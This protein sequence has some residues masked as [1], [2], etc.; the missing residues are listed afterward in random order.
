MIWPIASMNAAVA[1][2]SLGSLRSGETWSGLKMPASLA[3]AW[4]GLCRG[5]HTRHSR[6]KCAQVSYAAPQV[7]QAREVVKPDLKQ[8]ALRC[9]GLVRS[10]EMA[11][12]V[13]R[14]MVRDE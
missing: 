11:D 8:K 10:W 3:A 13:L 12:V 1:Q 5:S 6:R 2:S 4:R 9:E 7:S 14:E